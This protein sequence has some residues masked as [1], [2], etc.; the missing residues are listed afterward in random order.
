MGDS[1][2]KPQVTQLVPL[3]TPR[4]LARYTVWHCYMPNLC[5]R[6]QKAHFPKYFR[7]QVHHRSYTPV[8]KQLFI[9][10]PQCTEF[11]AIN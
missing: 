9:S 1:S 4:I 8:D 5:P 2:G 7:V 10:L 11:K 3:V 6:T